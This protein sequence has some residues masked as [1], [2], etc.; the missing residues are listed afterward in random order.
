M[1]SKDPYLQQRQRLESVLREEIPLT[2]YIGI[3]VEHYDGECLRLRAPLEYNINHKRT[4]FGGSLY[5]VAVLCGWGLLYLK[6]EEQGLEG[7]IVIHS[8]Q[9]HY[10]LPVTQDILAETAFTSNQQTGDW[11]AK[12]RR[13]G[14]VRVPLSIQ[15]MQGADTAFRLDARYV[16]HR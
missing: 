7:H 9:A 8:S 3:A 11:L 10:S 12:Y 6:L 5:S 4:A 13:K 1:D 15:V 16:I 14:M 2:Q